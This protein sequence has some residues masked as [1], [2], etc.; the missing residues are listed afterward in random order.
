M[1]NIL[2][3]YPTS[4]SINLTLG[5]A[6]E[7]LIFHRFKENS[8]QLNYSVIAECHFDITQLIDEDLLFHYKQSLVEINLNCP[9]GNFLWPLQLYFL[10]FN[11]NH[12]AFLVCKKKNVEG[13]PKQTQTCHQQQCS[14]SKPEAFIATINQHPLSL[15]QK[16]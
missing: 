2:L 8:T 13:I 1:K 10:F 7:R 9:L 15:F 14:N 5:L 4:F 12:F 11:Y 3:L 16:N 6:S